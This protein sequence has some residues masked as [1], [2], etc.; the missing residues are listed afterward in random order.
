[1]PRNRRRFLFTTFYQLLR[2]LE[3]QLR[4]NLITTRI[5]NRAA[6]SSECRITVGVVD[7]IATE[8]VVV[9]DV[10]DIERESNPRRHVT[11]RR[12]ILPKAH[13]N[14]LVRE[15]SGNGEARRIEWVLCKIGRV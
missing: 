14:V 4:T 15:R 7:V 8:V 12:E 1:M 13:V 9:E 6:S 11:E 2:G 10:E 3:V 5:G